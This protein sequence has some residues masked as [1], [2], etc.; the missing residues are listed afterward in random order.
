[1]GSGEMSMSRVSFEGQVVIVTGAGGGL[2]S[3][4][5]REIARLGGAVVV[6]DLG[7]SVTGEGDETS[8]AYADT[9]VDAIRV[10]GGRAVA[11]YDTVASPQGA[12]HIVEAAMDNFGRV[13]AVIAA[14]GTMRYGDFESLSLEDLNSL[15]AVHV[16]GS[17]NIAQAVWPE[18]KR[19]GY[20]RVV[21]AASSAGALGNAQLAAYGAAKGGVIGLMHGLAEAG[22]P[23][24][25]LCNALMPNAMSRMTSGFRPGE[26]GDNPWSAALGRYFDPRYTVGLATFLASSACTSH[27]GIYSALGG[28]IGRTFIGVTD[29]VADDTLVDADWVAANWQ[30]IC[31][32]TRGFTVP[33]DL[34]DEFRIVAG[35]RGVVV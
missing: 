30:A 15:L 27:H 19:R 28:R 10:A 21:F 7:G 1:M 3:V 11:N 18:M 5:S 26:L 13:D 17:W 2:G 32:E 34:T 35:Q 33:T 20:G 31:D 24:G 8:P 6:N 12:R 22:K 16:G 14:A 29:G 23:H 9:V 4:F 25:I